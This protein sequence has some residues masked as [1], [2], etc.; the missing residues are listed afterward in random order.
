MS[1]RNCPSSMRRPASRA[2]APPT[3]KGASKLPWP[4]LRVW[5]MPALLVLVTMALY[6]PATRCDF[7]NY[8]DDWNITE[9]AH[10]RN[11]LIWENMARFLLDP[12]EPPGWSP[13]TMW[14]HM[15]ICQVVGLNPWVHHLANV[16]LH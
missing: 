10:V 11:G 8:D 5:L 6:W 7:I 3:R 13:L 12:L 9:N 16:V 1:L 4:H 2:K 14:S 15:A